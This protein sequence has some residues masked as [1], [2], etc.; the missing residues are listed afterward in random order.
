MVVVGV[1]PCGVVALVVVGAAPCGVV[2]LVVVG[3]APCGS[4][5]LCFALSANSPDVPPSPRPSRPKYYM[6][7]E[8]A[9][10]GKCLPCPDGARCTAVGTTLETLGVEPGWYRWV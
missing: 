9:T 1:A 2:A 4:I 7:T 10:A 6:F 3:V 8:Q 5:C